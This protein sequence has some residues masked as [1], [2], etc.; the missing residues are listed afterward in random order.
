M[1]MMRSSCALLLLGCLF[2]CAGKKAEVPATPSD[3][4]DYTLVV[5]DSADF[6]KPTQFDKSGLGLRAVAK[7][8]T[9][10]LSAERQAAA[11]GAEAGPPFAIGPKDLALITGPTREDLVMLDRASIDISK[12]TLLQ[13]NPGDRRTTTIKF[14]FRKDLS[15]TRLVYNNPRQNIRFPVPVE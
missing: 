14:W 13:L 6:S 8:D 15:G 4:D 11:E 7:G 2:G 1:I 3:P 12:F 9:I 5:A 10:I